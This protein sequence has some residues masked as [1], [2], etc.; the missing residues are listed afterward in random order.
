M[1][2][3]KLTDQ[4]IKGSFDQECARGLRLLGPNTLDMTVNVAVH[5]YLESGPIHN[6]FQTVQAF[7]AIFPTGGCSL[8]PTAA[9]EMEKT[10]TYFLERVERNAPL[11]WKKMP[12]APLGFIAP[13]IL[14]PTWD[15]ESYFPTKREVHYLHALFI[16][17]Y[18]S[19]ITFIEAVFTAFG[20]AELFVPA[21]DKFDEQGK[22]FQ[23][24]SLF[25]FFI[26]LPSTILTTFEL[27]PQ[28]GKWLGG[29]ALSV[30][31]LSVVYPFFKPTPSKL[32]RAD[33]WSEKIRF[34][35]DVKE[36]RRDYVERISEGLQT[37]KKM[38][39]V[40]KSGIGKTETALAF[41]KAVTR[42]EIPAFRG[43]EVFCF[44]T[45]QLI[46]DGW[47]GNGTVL[48]EI[49][50][51]MGYHQKDLIIVFDELQESCKEGKS[52]MLAQQLKTLLDRVS[53]A[54]PYFI[55]ITTDEEYERD[56]SM[57]SAFSRR[58]ET[59]FIEQ[60][61]EAE[62]TKIL[63]DLL[64][65][66]GPEV[67]L[68]D[69]QSTLQYLIKEA[70]A[71]IPEV[72]QISSAVDPSVEVLEECLKLTSQSQSPDRNQKKVEVQKEVDFRL[73]QE[74]FAEPSRL[75]TEDRL[76]QNIQLQARLQ[77]AT[78]RVQS[79]ESQREQFFQMREQLLELKKEM[80]RLLL[81]PSKKGALASIR[82]LSQYVIP[83]MTQILKGRAETLGLRTVIDRQLIDQAVQTVRGKRKRES[84]V[85]KEA[86]KAK[87]KRRE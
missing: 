32:P 87:T 43:K 55:G 63:S 3:S 71:R 26:S 30:I 1:T 34:G 85:M 6:L 60:P 8:T 42:G 80:M 9:R 72:G 70:R 84:T 24:M 20:I 2:I 40:G 51:K 17:A 46:D 16:K 44:N 69:H 79:H 66:K 23:A 12:L 11:S 47:Q 73:A 49:I 57:Q 78:R 41:A 5:R 15:R 81:Q 28:F 74:V 61:D 68:E 38:M 25:H 18:H 35:L 67:F 58:F 77:E 39:L 76:K 62:M 33:N 48:R 52:G 36:G 4:L 82:V 54:F 86:Q 14:V 59:L 22:S 50:K 31:G 7:A 21:E 10:A 19:C 27:N 56:V 37:G 64:L 75:L 13:S 53:D 45:A 29:T 65:E 83:K